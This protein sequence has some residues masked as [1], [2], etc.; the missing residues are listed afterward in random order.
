MKTGETPDHRETWIT[1]EI[2]IIRKKNSSRKING[3][4]R[5]FAG[6]GVTKS[7]CKKHNQEVLSL[8]TTRMKKLHKPPTTPKIMFS[9]FDFEEVVLGYDNPMIIAKMVNTEVKRVFID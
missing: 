5:G 4:V 9:S 1:Y 3:I 7:A 2:M 6:G 8:S